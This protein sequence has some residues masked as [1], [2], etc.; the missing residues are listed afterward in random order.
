MK[1]CTAKIVISC[2]RSWEESVSERRI[3][4]KSPVIRL[5][6]PSESQGG[7]LVEGTGRAEEGRVCAAAV[8][9]LPGREPGA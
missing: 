1:L 7:L 4:K 8:D 3:K 9:C 2:M 6:R 5:R